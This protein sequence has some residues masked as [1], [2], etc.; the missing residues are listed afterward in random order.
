[1]VCIVL[2]THR[3]EVS[4]QYGVFGMNERGPCPLLYR[5]GE[6]GYKE[7]SRS[8]YLLELILSSFRVD[9]I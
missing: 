3:E 6:Q 5:P 7:G 1:M 9:S 2:G 4:M 8:V